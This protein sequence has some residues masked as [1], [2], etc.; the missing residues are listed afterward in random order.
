[1]AV[2]GMAHAQSVNYSELEGMFREPVTTSVTGKP[3]RASEAPAALIIVTRED[4]RRSP[5]HDIPGLI[6]AYAG[7]DV[8][9]WTAGHSDIAVRGGVLPFNPRLLVL[10]NGRQVYLD[11]YGMTNWDGLG[12]QLAEIQQIEVVKG[13]N[14]ALFGFNAASGVINIITVNPLHSQQVTMSAGMGTEGQR[15]ASGAA[16]VKLAEALG[17]RLSAGYESSDELDGLPASPL[18]SQISPIS[19]DPRHKEVTAEL[20]AKPGERTDGSISITHSDNQR[21]EVVPFLFTVSSHYRFT[22]LGARISRDTGWG[23]LSAHVFQNWSD[24]GGLVAFHNKVLATSADALVRAGRANTVRLGIEYRSNRFKSKP[25]YPGATQYN[26][27]AANGM[28]ETRFSDAATFTIAARIDHLEL[29]QM[30]IVNQPTIFTNADF[31][32]SI[33]EWSFNSAL[34]LKLDEGNSIRLAVGKGIQAPSLFA[35]GA[36]LDFPIRGTPLS[37]VSSGNPHINPAKIWSAEIGF[38]HMLGDKGR[39]EMT[40][41]YNR[42]SDVMSN[43]SYTTPPRATPPAYPFILFTADNV[44]TFEAYG[45]EASASGQLS[46]DWHWSLN[47]TWTRAKQHIAGNADGQFTRPLALD[48][49]TPEHKVKAQLSYEHGP[50]LAT[51]AARY[52]SATRQ[53]VTLA[54]APS[55]PLRLIDVDDSLAVDAKLALRIK[56]GLTF[57]VAG[58]NL[59]GA[60]GAYLSPVPAE[61]RLRAS[62]QVDF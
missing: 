29:Q 25:G 1:M 7:I 20:Y 46:P 21:M 56:E 38:T 40:A 53:L 33:T 58:E 32:R 18:A 28:W 15:F 10:V 8:A 19:H 13:P 30:G 24:I 31:D 55:G 59:T 16:S 34:L 36:R 43:S 26:V 44:G 22:S 50:W 41:F 54:P 3:Q 11:H 35:F 12:V 6:Q 27:Y 42:T 17:V 2:P 57:A 14:S 47:Y 49:A 51:V 5:A 62:L 61:R 9:R 48:S 37:A 60:D 39:F 23:V 52:T 4:I 45:L